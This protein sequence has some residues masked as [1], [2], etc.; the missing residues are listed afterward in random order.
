M[1]VK[2]NCYEKRLQLSTKGAVRL[3]FWHFQDDVPYQLIDLIFWDGYSD[4]FTGDL[5]PVDARKLA[6]MLINAADAYEAVVRHANEQKKAAR[7]GD[8]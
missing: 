8:S 4:A 6:A 1:K 2:T 5:S 3:E 7:K